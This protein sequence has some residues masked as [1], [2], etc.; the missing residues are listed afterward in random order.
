LI[1]GDLARK[2]DTYIEVPGTSH[3]DGYPE[4][5]QF[6]W[7]QANQ[8]FVFVILGAARLRPVIAMVPMVVMI[9]VSLLALDC[10]HDKGGQE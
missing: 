1:D 7:A 2:T 8:I 10:G 4:F 6:G 3:I 9:V 5:S